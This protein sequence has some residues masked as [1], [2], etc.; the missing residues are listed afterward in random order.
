MSSG[1]T[2]PHMAFQYQFRA[3]PVIALRSLSNLFGGGERKLGLSMLLAPGSPGHT[4]SSAQE[5]YVLGTTDV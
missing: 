4:S 1:L 2:P 3:C 5:D